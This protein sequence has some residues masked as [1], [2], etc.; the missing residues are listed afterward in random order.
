MNL[1]E[2]YK[3]DRIKTLFI[4]NVNTIIL[5]IIMYVT[6]RQDDNIFRPLIFFSKIIS[7][8]PE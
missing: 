2:T 1:L 4:S 6:D 7:A 8:L 3:F 5:F